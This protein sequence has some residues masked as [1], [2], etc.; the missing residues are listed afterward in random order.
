MRVECEVEDVMIH[1]PDTGED[2]PGVCVTCT[3]CEH[4]EESFGRTARSVRRCLAL[5]R[6]N[7]PEGMSNFY[8]PDQVYPEI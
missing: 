8:V 2:Q 6:E 5:L 4:C 1:N 7:C 3:E